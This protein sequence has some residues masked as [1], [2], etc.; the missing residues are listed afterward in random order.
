MYWHD[1]IDIGLQRLIDTMDQWL[2]FDIV[3]D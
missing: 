2:V 1:L 3:L